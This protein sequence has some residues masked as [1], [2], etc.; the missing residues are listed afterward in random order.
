MDDENDIGKT[1]SNK[2]NEKQ[3]LKIYKKEKIGK[4]GI[5]N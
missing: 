3:K 5:E 4:I 1:E 2:K